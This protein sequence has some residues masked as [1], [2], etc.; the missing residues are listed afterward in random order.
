MKAGDAQ[1]MEAGL[2]EMRSALLAGDM[3]RLAAVSA[4]IVAEDTLPGL[5]P[6]VAARL[7][8]KAEAN[9][10]LLAAALKGLKAA[11]R[12][13]AELAGAGQFSTYDAS[14]QRCRPEAPTAFPLRRA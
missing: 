2:D 7:R 4:R 5:T 6:P 1:A 10:R 3:A 13:A 14:G 8:V 11:Q 9:A 12:R